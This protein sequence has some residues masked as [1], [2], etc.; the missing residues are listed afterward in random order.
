MSLVSSISTAEF[1]LAAPVP[2]TGAGPFL[3]QNYI[4]NRRSEGKKLAV[5]G[6][7]DVCA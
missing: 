5:D 2:G 4:R 6:Q 1:S 7:Y 3:S